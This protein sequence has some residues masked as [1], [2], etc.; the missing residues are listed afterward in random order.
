[1]NL[2]YDF[3]EIKEYSMIYERNPTVII[4]FFIGTILLFIVIFLVMTFSMDKEYVITTQGNVQSEDVIN[5]SF[6]TSGKVSK[7]NYKEGD[8]IKKDDVLCEIDD[9]YY[10][11][12]IEEL[13][14]NNELDNTKE[15]LLLKQKDCVSLQ[16]ND[17][18]KN[19]KDEAT[20][21]YKMEVYLQN[22]NNLNNSK[23]NVNVEAQQSVL[24]NNALSE[25]SSEMDAANSELKNIKN[26]ISKIDRQISETQD[27]STSAQLNEQRQTFITQGSQ[28]ERQIELIQMRQKSIEQYKNLFDKNKEDERS[29]YYKIEAY[30]NS[31]SD[32]ENRKTGQNSELNIDSQKENLKNDMLLEINNQLSDIKDRKEAFNIKLSNL[33]KEASNLKIT[34]PQNGYIHYLIPVAEGM[35]VDSSKPYIK[36]NGLVSQ[37]ANMVTMI[38]ASYIKNINVGHNVKVSFDLQSGYSKKYM[39]GSI[40]S[41]DSDITSDEFGGQGYYKAYIKTDESIN[42]PRANMPAEVKIIYDKQKWI[43]F[44]LEM[45]SF[46]KIA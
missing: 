22:I 6:P 9:S 32:I 3:D 35:S 37:N 33:E 46:K 38:P 15:K 11:A 23:S 4:P 16:K 7:I 5:I 14:L 40:I 12:Q 17:F 31:I 28:K 45:L 26:E 41:I 43:D 20:F 24:R 36:L 1:M 39:K 42:N 44:I 34:A 21:Y 10:K 18:D 19:N 13:K 8:A 27:A 30:F 2:E 25:A 29:N